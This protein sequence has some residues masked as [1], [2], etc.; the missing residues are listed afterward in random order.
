MTD[1]ES[2]PPNRRLGKI[3]LFVAVVLIGGKIAV[4]SQLEHTEPDVYTP[5]STLCAGQTVSLVFLLTAMRKD[6]FNLELIK[7]IPRITWFWMTIGTLLFTVLSPMLVFNAV[8]TVNVT[9]ITIIQRSEVIFLL[10]LAKPLG[11]AEKWPSK[12]EIGN[13]FLIALGI[14]L[15]LLLSYEYFHPVS[16]GYLM[17]IVSNDELMVFIS[18]LCDPLSIIINKRFVTKVP[19]GF[20]VCYRQILGTILYHCIALLRGVDVFCFTSST[21]P[22]LWI[23]MLWFGPW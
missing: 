13:C 14:V 15:T 7:S 16:G 6:V 11:I 23:N 22:K 5:C 20:F 3:C 18:T 10:F 12:W 21:V 2:K 9:R 19:I 4:Y 17:H 8:K 1:P